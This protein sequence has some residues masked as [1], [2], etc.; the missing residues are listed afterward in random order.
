[1]NAKLPCLFAAAALAPIVALADTAK[2]P[3][4]AAALTISIERGPRPHEPPPETNSRGEVQMHPR[5]A[6][7][8]DATGRVIALESTDAPPVASIRTPLE[9]AIRGWHFQPGTVDGRPAETRTTLALDVSLVEH[10]ADQ[11]ALRVD[12]ART[13]ADLPVKGMHGA[14]PKYP[15][16]AVSHKKQGIVVLRVDY[17]AS[18]HVA[19]ARLN[20]GAPEVDAAL[21]RTAAESAKRWTFTPEVV[22]GRG[23][24]GSSIVPI[25]FELHL[26]HDQTTNE[27]CSWHPPSGHDG[28]GDGA[29]VAIDPAAR[30]DTNV[31]GSTL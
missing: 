11:F 28:L 26:E 22:G 14:Y 12:D 30:L 24:A 17:D 21:V 15:H 19:G 29:I 2:A 7:T 9:N 16:D 13:G 1:M 31:V 27:G 23:L 10:G 4:S 20:D 18:G 5:W 8:L 3:V 6:V 25:C